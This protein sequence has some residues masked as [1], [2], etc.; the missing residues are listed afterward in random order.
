D[1]VVQNEIVAQAGQREVD[2]TVVFPSGGGDF[3]V[4]TPVTGR[5]DFVGFEAE[6]KTRLERLDFD[7]I[8]KIGSA[9]AVEFLDKETIR[10]RLIKFIRERSFIRAGDVGLG[11]LLPVG[12][13]QPH[14]QI[15][16]RTEA[17]RFARKDQALPR[18]GGKFKPVAIF[19]F[20]EAAV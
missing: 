1:V 17:A 6:G 5:L 2:G 11:E 7:A 20:Q 14:E 18:A 4:K 19:R 15:A 3:E 12:V 16:R 8:D 10:A 9:A 13:E